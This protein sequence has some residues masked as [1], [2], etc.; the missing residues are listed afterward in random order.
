MTIWALFLII[1]LLVLIATIPAWP[2][3]RG[4]GYSPVGI[5]LAALLFVV[6]LWGIGVVELRGVDDATNGGNGAPVEDVDE[7]PAE[8]GDEEEPP[9]EEEEEE[10]TPTE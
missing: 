2:H 3:S 6:L 10:G 4:W 5:V 7:T 8:N 1:L 9:D